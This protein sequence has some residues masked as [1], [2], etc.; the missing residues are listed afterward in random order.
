MKNNV[1]LS[2][3]LVLWL[4][5]GGL[6]GAQ[7]S[8]VL[9]ENGKSRYTI[10]L[11][12]DPTP[13]EV[14]AAGLFQQTLKKMCGA[15]LPILRAPQ[16]KNAFEVLIGRAA[17]N[18]AAL[19]TILPTLREDDYW[20]ATRGSKLLITG[21]SRKGVIYGV[22]SLLEDEL[23]YRKL[24]VNAEYVP[25]L[26]KVS[27][28]SIEK[29]EQAA[30][31]IRI[32]QTAMAEDED[33]RDFRKLAL[34]GEYWNDG[35][36]RGYYVH[37][38]ERLLPRET[39][40]ESHPEYFSLV[41][42]QR[43]PYG[44][45]CLS[46]P[47]V[48]KI[49]IDQLRSEMAA[50]PSIRYWSVSQNDNFEHCQCAKCR[51]IDSLEGSPAGLMLR[52]V[53]EVARAFPDKV[54]TTLAYQYTRT[55]PRITKPEKNVMITLCTIELDRCHPIETN[56]AGASFVSDIKGWSQL[57]SNIMLWDYEVQFTNYLCPFPLFHTL[58][59]NI[60]F[61]D[62]YGVDAHFQQCNAQHNVEFS[63]LKSYYLSHLLWNPDETSEAVL[64]DFFTYYYGDAAPYVRQ[65]FDRIHAECINAGQLLD[66]YGTPVHYANTFLTAD[67]L[68]EYNAA[69]NLAE[70]AVK[71]HPVLLERVA[72]QRL[73]LMYAEMEIGKSDLFGPRGWYAETAGGQFTVRP[74]MR[75]MLDDFYAIALRNKVINLNENGLT[76]ESWYQST[77]RFIDTQV[78]GN[79]AFRK[80]VS[81]RPQPDKRYWNKGPQTLTNGVKGTDDYKINWLG[82]ENSD[83]EL[84]LD[85]EKLQSI[86][87][88]SLGSLQYPKSWIIHPVQIALSWSPDS[89]SWSTPIQ[90]QQMPDKALDRHIRD[91]TWTPGGVSARFLK[92][93]ITATKTLPLWH[94]YSGKLSW[95][96]L[97][98]IVVR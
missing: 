31:T 97:D 8:C 70:E 91:F 30:A 82:W 50:H 7:Q 57:T 98:E 64:N 86:Q 94:N 12:A 72:L 4:L 27:L 88:V 24:T 38:F 89:L 95:F 19:S 14:R 26:T 92:F 63:D 87:T 16:K 6:V 10:V 40:F 58:Q 76:T 43:I 9:A 25:L 33:Y 79:L 45:L 53:N 36:W 1:S 52:F 96:F 90:L 41:N 42:G 2:L 37:T 60:Q 74:G 85:L 68:K 21:G 23:G 35:D 65:Y 59:P 46:H 69:L 56:P 5:S 3:L 77:L 83:A 67:L 66:I 28:P 22:T 93:T 48:L 13:Q 62:R 73:P 71:D 39:Y 49:T 17:H 11:P 55:P 29:S 20:Y 61:F 44:Q 32:V 51:A 84:V 18:D 34:I 15:E 47:D 54:I 80:N 78:Q 75:R 81:C